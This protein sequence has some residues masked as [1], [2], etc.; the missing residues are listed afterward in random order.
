MARPKN[1]LQK[2]HPIIQKRRAI[3]AGRVRDPLLDRLLAPDDGHD[4]HDGHDVAP[5]VSPNAPNPRDVEG[6]RQRRRRPGD[7]GGP[8]RAYVSFAE[9]FPDV[10]ID[11]THLG[12]HHN[13]SIPNHHAPRPPRARASTLQRVSLRAKIVFFCWCFGGR[14]P[15]PPNGAPSNT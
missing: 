15:K 12:A 13:V 1:I 5:A 2:H 4:G 3:M 6:N 7:V 8:G 9:A 11:L 10:E 14:T